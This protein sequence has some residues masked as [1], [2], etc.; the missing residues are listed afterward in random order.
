MAAV[1]RGVRAAII[2]LDGTMLDTMPDF[3]VAI[4]LMREELGLAPIGV[5]QIELMVGKGSENLVRRVLALDYG[6]EGVERLFAQA[7]EAYQRHYLVING[8]HSEVYADVVAGLQAMKANGLRLA[9]VTNKPVAF[10]KPLL[11]L[12]GLD[13][14]FEVLFGGDSFEKKKPH[15]MPLLKACEHF[16]L[17][18]AQVVAIGDSSNDAE[19]ARAAGCPV[20]TV[21]YG[22]N[23]GVGIHET[24]S[25]G[26]VDTLLHA[27]EL[28]SSAN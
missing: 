6:E 16:D 27:A 26:I 21:P 10:A 2:D 28:I 24:D 3:E 19:A 14:Y 20:L 25:D 17:P 18:P 12:K 22:Y 5:E 7:M 9:C 8:R 13:G 4:N 1:L 23:H 15:P 11:A